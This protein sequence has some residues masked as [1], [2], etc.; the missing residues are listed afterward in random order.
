D[1][2][3]ANALQ[4]GLAR[5]EFRHG[6]W[7]G[8]LGGLRFDLLISNP[9]YIA[10]DDPVMAAGALAREPRIALTPGEDALASLRAIVRGAPQHLAPGGWLLLEHGAAQGAQVRHE[11]V[12]AG[13]GY[14]R[15]HTD[16]AGHERMTEAQHG[17]I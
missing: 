11:L 6:S 13:F 4:L 5:I 10:A 12:L 1:V 14:V 15:S 8:P 2:A 7:F 16:L 3:R 17:Q 9:P